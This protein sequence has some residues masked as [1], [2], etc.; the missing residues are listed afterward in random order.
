MF[1]YPE[2]SKICCFT[3]HRPE[4][5][6]QPEE[7]IKEL[8]KIEI[9]RAVAEGYTT[10]ISGMARGVDMWAAQLV[11]EQRTKNDSLQ[12]I[13]AVPIPGFENK[14]EKRQK[15]QYKSIL[16]QANYV[17]PPVSEHYFAGCFQVRNTY[18]VDKSSLVIALFNGQKGGTKNTVDY[19]KRCGVEVR[20]PEF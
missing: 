15:E 16:K 14:W 18:M 6:G 20:C 11:L 1:N 9:E 12:L 13:C 10:F 17:T 4:K 8:L 19:A 7:R 2:K 3:G 5:L